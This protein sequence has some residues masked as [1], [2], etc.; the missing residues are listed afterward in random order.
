LNVRRAEGSYPEN[1]TVKYQVRIDGK[2]VTN[3]ETKLDSSGYTEIKFD[4]PKEIEI[5]EGV[6]NCII[7]DNGVVETKT[8]TIPILLQFM[9]VQVFPEGGD[10]IKGLECG[11]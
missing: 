11:N 5:G 1:A 10:L 7:D 8:K 6:L 3:G 4:L 9:D 2:D